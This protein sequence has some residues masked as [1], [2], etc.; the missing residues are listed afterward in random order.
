VK[1]AGMWPVGMWIFRSPLF[2][3]E[4]RK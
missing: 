1:R 4:L 3:S 2:L